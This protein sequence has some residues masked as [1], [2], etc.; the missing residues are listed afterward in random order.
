MLHL[1]GGI[2]KPST[3]TVYIGETDI[4]KLKAKQPDH[5]R[6]QH[7]GIIFQ[8]PRF[9]DSLSVV[10]NLMLAPYFSGSAIKKDRA[11]E[12]IAHLQISEQAIKKT[13]VLSQG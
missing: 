13:S 2:L 12:L 9:I 5:F 11:K 7:I 1:L 6:G 10:E 8:Q 4:T 3:G